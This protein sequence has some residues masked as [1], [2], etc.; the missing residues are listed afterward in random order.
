MTSQKKE[1]QLLELMSRC[2]PKSPTV[3]VGLFQEWVDLECDS[4]IKV[5]QLLYEPLIAMALP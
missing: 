5:V 1:K 4:G 3:T 2:P